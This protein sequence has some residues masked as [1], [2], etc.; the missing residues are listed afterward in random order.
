MSTQGKTDGKLSGGKLM[1]GGLYI[2]TLLIVLAFLAQSSVP[3]LLP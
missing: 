1:A 2:A 3:F